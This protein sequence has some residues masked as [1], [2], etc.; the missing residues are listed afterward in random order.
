[1]GSLCTQIQREVGASTS[2]LGDTEMHRQDMAHRGH[3]P[4]G[5]RL[6]SVGR[7]VVLLAFESDL[8]RY[9]R[10]HLTFSWLQSHHPTVL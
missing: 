9:W 4:T 6:G 7:S 5:C 2:E 1:M 8:A 3:K 10:G